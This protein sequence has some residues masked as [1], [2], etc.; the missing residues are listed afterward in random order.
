MKWLVT[1]TI[2][3]LAYTASPSWARAEYSCYDDTLDEIPFEEALEFYDDPQQGTPPKVDSWN[4]VS[5]IA[6]LFWDL[7][8]TILQQAE[9]VYGDSH[10]KNQQELNQYF[11]CYKTSSKLHQYYLNVL[12]PRIRVAASAFNKPYQLVACL[13]FRESGGWQANILSPAGARGLPQ[14][15]PSTYQDI[16]NLLPTH[17]T[18][19]KFKNRTPNRALANQNGCYTG[20]FALNDL[21]L[22]RLKHSLAH[23]WRTYWIRR[24]PDCA[25][26]RQ[27]YGECPPPLKNVPYAEATSDP[28]IAAGLLSLHLDYSWHYMKGYRLPGEKWARYKDFMDTYLVQAAAYN[29]GP[30]GTG[31][32]LRVSDKLEVEINP[33]NFVRETRNHMTSIRNCMEKGNWDPP[34]RTDRV[35]SCGRQVDDMP[36]TMPSLPPIDIPIDTTSHPAESH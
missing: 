24:I 19:P 7:T 26:A 35:K 18:E 32:R 11:D 27:L 6:A 1:L 25:R 16:Q 5:N 28:T 9:K 2:L 20:R 4:P 23:K 31:C 3:L 17:L 33:E 12:M 13:M 30:G 15:M 14:L 22:D 34:P 8:Q 29:T 21:E 36:E 10:L